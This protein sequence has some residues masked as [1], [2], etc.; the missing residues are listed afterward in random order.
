M[1]TTE[2]DEKDE[3]LSGLH[4]DAMDTSALTMIPQYRS[5]C[6]RHRT[7]FY[8]LSMSHGKDIIKAFFEKLGWTALSTFNHQDLYGKL[9]NCNL[10]VWCGRSSNS[11]I[12]MRNFQLGFH[13][14]SIIR[15]TKLFTNK[16]N[17]VTTLSDSKEIGAI[18]DPWVLSSVPESYSVSSISQMQYFASN[19]KDD[20]IWIC[21]P[22]HLNRGEGIHLLRSKEDVEECLPNYAEGKWLLQKYV[23][24]PL[25]LNG[26]K[27]DLRVY[28]LIVILPN[29]RVISFYHPGYIRVTCQP[30]NIQSTDLTV[31]LTNQAV[32]QQHEA[33]SSERENTIWTPQQLE[34]Y[35]DE[36]R[37]KFGVRESWCQKS[38]HPNIKRI[39][40]RLVLNVQN[41]LNK[42]P[43]VFE[44]FGCD[45][46]V[47]S[48][49]KVW[50]LEVNANPALG[51][52]CAAQ[53]DI[54]PEVVH[55]A[56]G[57]GLES[58][59]RAFRQK[60]ITAS[61][62]SDLLFRREFQ[63][64]SDSL[65]RRQCRTFLSTQPNQSIKSPLANGSRSS[66]RSLT[67]KRPDTA[68]RKGLRKATSALSLNQPSLMRR[69]CPTGVG[70]LWNLSEQRL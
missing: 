70:S 68:G 48:Q 8:Y 36:N 67:H 23:E 61:G 5:S 52:Y 9:K 56:L 64:L 27:F 20:D 38:L 21:K 13:H 43:G 46:L 51:L 10:F 57:I 2:K 33:Y 58:T 15:N 59:G 16:I 14:L 32:Q 11:D 3:V 7:G 12:L 37:H 41:R 62:A 24:K 22:A 50:L 35:V 45:F 49:M 17:L 63:W 66:T 40:Q 54:I 53:A 39:L 1:V 31:H 28:L 26:R 4:K 47:D 69:T 19:F 55:E 25:L 65:Q 34:K 44:L 42:V 60:P 29:E 6:I 18:W 30:Y